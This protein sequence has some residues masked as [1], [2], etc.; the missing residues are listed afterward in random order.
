M[1][2]WWHTTGLPSL[3]PSI[4]HSSLVAGFKIQNIHIKLLLLICAWRLE[5]F[6]FCTHKNYPYYTKY[7]IW[8]FIN[9]AQMAELPF[10]LVA[11]LGFWSFLYRVIDRVLFFQESEVQHALEHFSAE[12]EAVEVKI[13]TSKSKAMCLFYKIKE[14]YFIARKRPCTWKSLLRS[15][16]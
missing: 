4:T 3:H 5:E 7:V 2:C 14:N 15:Y 1:L 9:A 11:T 8:N 10:L 6:P 12:C 16:S 13:C